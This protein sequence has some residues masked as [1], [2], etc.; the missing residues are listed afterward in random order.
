M[1]G[2]AEREHLRE[3][4]ESER[5]RLERRLAREEADLAVHRKRVS[6][7][8]PCAVLSPG[9]ATEDAEQEVRSRQARETS[10]Q[11]RQSEHAL[12]RLLADPERFGR[13]ARCD[14]AISDA[15]LDVLPSTPVC[16]R[17]A[18]GER[19][20]EAPAPPAMPRRQGRGPDHAEPVRRLPA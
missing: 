1:L 19:L 9:A 15:R 4:L 8:D 6:E 20:I 16:E 2:P 10:R 3:R 13:C 12:Q 14:G 11:L 5:A 18:A 17:C 7:R